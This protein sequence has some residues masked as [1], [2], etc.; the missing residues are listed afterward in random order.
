MRSG[1]GPSIADVGEFALID[2]INALVEREAGRTR[3]FARHVRVG[4]GDDSAVLRLPAGHELA[5]S[6]DAFVENVHF[7]WET[8]AAPSI[9]RCALAASLSDLAAMG[10]RPLGFTCAIAA[11]PALSLARFDGLF[12]GLSAAAADWASPLVGGNVT[13]GAET[14]LALTV[15][16]ALP[17]GRALLRSSLQAGD[18]LFVTGTLGA[19]AFGVAR[20]RRGR[21][22]L[23]RVPEP[24]LAAGRALARM[25]HRGACIDISDGLVADLAHL[26][27]C[28]ASA[29]G[30]AE[31][32]AEIDVAAI[33]RPRGFKGDCARAGLDDDLLALTGGEDY[34]L[35]FSLREGA[36]SPAVLSRRM[37]LRVTE[38][39]CVTD[40]PGI[41]GVAGELLEG[42]WRHF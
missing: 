14:S 15:F 31:L 9:G 32:G 41:H 1:A 8:R 28:S 38:V 6:S 22:Q 20:S 19:A 7:R 17:A 16:G 3:A 13:R 26:L 40:R 18:R 23:R 21:R 36:P 11:P 5:V 30:G 12:R 39:G 42:G 33:P 10:A 29:R 27:D 25:R 2:R 37:G 4:I 35:L 34:E 24:R